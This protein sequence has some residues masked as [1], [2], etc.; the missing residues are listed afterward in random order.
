MIISIDGR[1]MEENLVRGDNLEDILSDL[2]E[3]HLPQNRM[4]GEVLLNGLTFTEELPHAAVEVP[5]N[6]IESLV[7]VTLTSEDISRHFLD[8]SPNILGSMLDSLPKITEL[9]RLG[10]E[11]EANEHY[12]R[13]L[14]SLHL[15]ISM[16]EKVIRVMDI[17]YQ[18]SVGELGS[19]E[20]RLG[21]LAEIA[22]LLLRI[23]EENDWIYLADVLEYE[24]TPELEALRD[25]LP[26][27]KSRVH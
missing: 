27:L 7:L 2:T 13:F 16:L 22:S 6:E 24:L 15:T 4:V 11:T 12:L 14:E 3:N 5:R 1:P 17:P 20:G 25:M 10:D 9:F 19:I 21:W 18:A 23:Q 8:N 26:A